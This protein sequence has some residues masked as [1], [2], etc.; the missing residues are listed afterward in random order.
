MTAVSYV[1][2]G[3]SVS[4]NLRTR[5]TSHVPIGEREYQAQGAF[6]LTDFRK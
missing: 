2:W 6:N 4:K 3:K 1:I 5:H